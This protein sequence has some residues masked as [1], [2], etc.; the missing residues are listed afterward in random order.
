MIGDEE[1]IEIAKKLEN[2]GNID[3]KRTIENWAT[4][5]NRNPWT[6]Y[7]LTSSQKPLTL[8]GFTSPW[9]TAQHN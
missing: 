6:I 7:T 3:I 8:T 5:I 2:A 9:P 4:S 1:V